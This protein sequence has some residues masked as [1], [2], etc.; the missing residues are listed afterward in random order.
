VVAIDGAGVLT[1]LGPGEAVVSAECE[2]V[3]ASLVVEVLSSPIEEIELEPIPGPVAAGTTVRMKARVLTNRGGERKGPIS[4]STSD[5]SV[6]VITRDGWVEARNP[7]S[8]VII[9]SVGD[10]TAAAVLTVEA[11]IVTGPPAESRPEPPRDETPTT[12][13]APITMEPPAPEV[14]AAGVVA[15]EVGEV[16]MVETEAAAGEAVRVKAAGGARG[17]RWRWPLVTAVAAAGAIAGGTYL[18]AGGEPRGGRR[19]GAAEVRPLTQDFSSP[20]SVAAAP[21][22]R[23]SGTEAAP[24]GETPAARAPALTPPAAQASQPAPPDGEPRGTDRPTVGDRLAVTT[25]ASRSSRTG[26]VNTPAMEASRPAPARST[27]VSATPTAPPPASQSSA[28]PASGAPPSATP[29]PPPTPSPERA[30]SERSAARIRETVTGFVR[31][32][33][34]RDVKQ[35]ERLYPDA[36]K[37]W[38]GRWGPFMTDRR[39][40]RDLHASLI[41]FGQP[42]IT[43]ESSRVRFTILL[44]WNDM[45]NAKQQQRLDMTAALRAEG[46]GWTIRSLQ[47]ER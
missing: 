44:E 12:A 32:I 5:P 43:G 2:G 22:E 28:G 14:V 25:P 1:A 24:T 21:R 9:A 36:S 19:D 3:S 16:E 6:A 26:P 35:I 40:V 29:T 20:A 27:E 7:G 13:P 4:W 8:A 42:E 17:S 11:P 10:R 39:D 15:P 38:L 30:E 37:E 41:D 47:S 23:A 31:S 18:F 46:D 34:A 33:E 45:R